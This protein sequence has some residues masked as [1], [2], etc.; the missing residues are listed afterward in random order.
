MNQPSGL[1]RGRIFSSR[2]L[3]FSLECLGQGNEPGG[4]AES[5][6]VQDGGGD[7]D[8]DPVPP[9]GGEEVDEGQ[10]ELPLVEKPVFVCGV[11]RSG[12]TLMR[13]LQ[14][15]RQILH[16]LD[17]LG[18]E[19]SIDDFGNSYSAL[20]QLKQFPV[21]VLKIDQS[22][23]RNVPDDLNNKALTTAIIAMARSLSLRVIAEG[24]ETEKQRSLLTTAGCDF[25]QGYLYSKPLPAH[26]F[27]RFLEL[28]AGNERHDF[29]I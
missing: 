22:F 28:N 29:C 2:R 6:R 23:L 7:Q 17:E 12:T 27:E 4:I 8:E 16:R 9:L 18:V 10:R 11:H 13:D 19:I 14:Q 3:T 21:K 1:L 24:V 20:G 25:A 15:S 5:H 26:D